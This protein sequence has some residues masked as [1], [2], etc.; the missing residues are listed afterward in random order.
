[1]RVV[2]GANEHQAA[3]VILARSEIEVQSVSHEAPISEH[4]ALIRQLMEDNA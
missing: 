2:V 3:E 4:Q 1:M